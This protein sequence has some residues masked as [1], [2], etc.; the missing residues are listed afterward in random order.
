M[1]NSEAY[2]L[3]HDVGTTGNKTCLYRLGAGRLELVD[4]ALVEYPLYTLPNGGAE[5]HADDW[6][7]AVCEATR[8]V[9]RNAG[10]PPASIA[11]M[12]FCA[13]MQG[14]VPVGRDGQVLRP[15]MSY[16][17]NRA[18]AQIEKYLYTGLIRI[19]QWNAVKMLRWLALT[20]GAAA[21]VKDPLWKYL[22]LRENEPETFAA[23]S[24]WL[25]VK[26]ALILRATGEVT[27]GYDS[28]HATFLFDTRPGK[29]G[30]HAGLCRTF[31]V[32]IRHLPRVIHAT[33]VAGRLTPQA[34]AELGLVAGLPVLGGGGDL[35]LISVGAG[36]FDVNDAHIY[37]GTSGWVVATVDRRMTDIDGMVASILGAIPGRYNYISEQE[38]AG[39]CLQWVRDHLALDEIGVYLNAQPSGDKQQEQRSLYA[40]LNQAVA[41]TEPG[42]GGVLFTPWLH[43]NRSPFEDPLARGMFFNIGLETGKRQLIRAVLEGVAYNLR[44]MLETVEKKIPRRET[45]RFVGGGAQSPVWAQILADVTGRTIEVVENAQHVGTI[46]AAIVCAVG[47]GLLDSFQ[48]ARPL[49]GVQATYTPLPQYRALYD[50]NFAVYRRLYASNRKL[51]RQLNQR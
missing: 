47:L 5:Q 10:V 24:S 21:S 23:M 25:D 16:M 30:W 12:A 8:A 3:T 15:A 32:D 9:L 4:S 22:W 45:V 46:G 41:E 27:M 38:T 17:D 33:D 11:G 26:D 1:T 20:G 43:G 19:G 14:F 42:A 36:C 7:R 28:A 40:L 50:R 31:D 51:F 2:L 6:W 49:I 37:I 44:W 18:A 13:Q 39:R 48:E 34:A 35:S 29:L